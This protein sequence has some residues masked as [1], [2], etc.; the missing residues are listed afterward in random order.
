MKNI[1]NKHLINHLK[2][3]ISSQDSEREVEKIIFLLNI[4]SVIEGFYQEKIIK[5]R[6]V[7]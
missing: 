7:K 5:L 6:K 1:K 3:S 4:N 2:N